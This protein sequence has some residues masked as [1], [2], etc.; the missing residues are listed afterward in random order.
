[1]E[2][3]YKEGKARSIGVSNFTTHQLDD[4]MSAA[5]IKPMANQVEFHP[6]LQQPDLQ[7]FCQQHQ[8][9]YVAWSPIMRGHVLEIPELIE[10]GKKHHKN[11]VQV[12]MR[13]MVQ[14]DIV[15]IPK[16]SRKDR[17][18]SNADILDFVLNEQEIE[19]INGLDRQ[20]RIGQDPNGPGNF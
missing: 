4:L 17:I 1:M 19:T 5:T 16:S 15:T 9:Q 3:I 8:I 11:A 12:T 18:V 13:W 14:K 20:Y 10:I 7:I 2:K 6:R